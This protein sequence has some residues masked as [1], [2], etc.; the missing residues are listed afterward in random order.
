MNYSSI[1]EAYELNDSIDTD[2]NIISDNFYNYIDDINDNDNDNNNNNGN[3][4]DN[5]NDNINDNINDNRNDNGNN[6]GNI[7]GNDNINRN[8]NGNRNDNRNIDNNN[9]NINDNKNRNI[10]AKKLL[11]DYKTLIKILNENKIKSINL[12]KKKEDINNY[13][14]NIYNNHQNVML[15]LCRE[16]P[17]NIDTNEMTDYIIKYIE[18]FKKYADRWINE[19]YIINKNKLTENIEKQ[20][21]KLHA[22]RNLFINTTKEIIPLEKISKNICPICFENEINMCAIPCGH[23]CCNECVMQSLK[24]NNSKLTKCLNCR[25]TLKEYIKLFIQL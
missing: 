14:C 12:D 17:E 5:D 7:N 24:Y 25:N 20:E 13:K 2:Y 11:K 15:Q 3:R 9:D 10:D 19:Y 22:Y 1:N 8:N 18:L 21:I 23:T 4:N 16:T 6:N